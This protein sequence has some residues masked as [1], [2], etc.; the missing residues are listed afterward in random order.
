L[1]PIYRSSLAGKITI[2]DNTGVNVVGSFQ[3]ADK[4]THVFFLD[5]STDYVA[6]GENAFDQCTK[7]TNV[8]LPQTIT[9]IGGYAFRGDVELVNVNMNEGITEIG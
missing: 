9:K 3:Y 6:L 4:I 5:G 8:Y 2:P 1:K 7:L